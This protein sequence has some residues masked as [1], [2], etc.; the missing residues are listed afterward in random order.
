MSNSVN[1]LLAKIQLPGRI[2]N[3]PSRAALYND[4]E[5]DAQAIGGEIQVHPM[6]ALNEINLK[7]PD[8]LFNGKALVAVLGEC[9]PSIKKPL[10]LFGRDVDAILFFLRLVTYGPEY[11]I[12]VAH[13]CEG[14]KNHSYA[15]DLEKIIMNMKQLDPTI[16]EQK[17]MITLSTGHQ[18]YT[19]PMKIKD[20]V[21][22]FHSHGN[23][24]EL[25]DEDI[26]KL[27]VTN[28]MS[29]IEKVD[30]ITNR[31]FIEEWVRMLTTPMVT[32]ITDAAQ[33]LND[34][35]PETVTTLTCRDCQG[36][37]RVE[38]PLNPISFFSS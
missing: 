2:F 19:R 13:D 26:K 5:V 37:M 1:P 12:E 10:E 30:D 38:L 21:A 36:E 29:M 24:K 28:L 31:D 16:I 27:A 23:K 14:A 35:G 11:R 18:V 15:V 32:K 25:T 7:N 20:I 33:E 3:L 17:R 9:V 4:G 8:L 34:W 6:S 22:L